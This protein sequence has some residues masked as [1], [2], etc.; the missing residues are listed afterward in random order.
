M[1][2]TAYEVN[3]DGLVGPTHHYAGLSKGNLASM[4]NAGSRSNPRAAALE[5]LDKMKFMAD[6][7]FKQAVFPPHERPHLTTLK[8]LGYTGR[9]NRIP[10]KVFKDN[11]Q[12]LYQYSSAADMFAANSATVTPSI[13]SQ[14]N[15]V[16]FTPANKLMMPHRSIEAE[17]TSRIFEVIFPSHTFFQHHPRLPFNP[18]FLDEGAANHIRFSY[19]PNDPGLHLFVCGP[20]NNET[21]KKYPS[22]QTLE[23]QKAIVRSHQL[24]LDQVIYAEHS[25]EAL[26]NG[27]FHN[28][29]ISMGTANLFIFHEQAFKDGHHLIKELSEKFNTLSGKNL[30]L[31]KVS[32][33]EISLSDAV[34]S[35]FF[36][37]Q[38]VKIPDG[39]FVLFAPHQCK[40]Y[41]RV[42]EYIEKQLHDP[43]S[44]IADIHYV[45]LDQ[46]MRNGGGPACMR[47]PVLLT[48]AE[49]EHVHPNIFL[50][51]KLYNRL[52][53]W[54]SNYY[55]ECLVPNDLTD[56]ALVDE[57]HAALNE[58]TQ[59]LN[60]GHIYD[61]QR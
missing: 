27:V 43:D 6:F 52:K 51:D 46:C 15:R 44:P 18:L 9:D 39:G 38:L 20:W 59:I 2:P 58:L 23:A 35:Y 11:P 48:S 37:S 41:P 7:G 1:N 5:E 57:T 10:E 56:P 42:K 22:R 28:D 13:D 17:T 36:N 53:D 34:K 16:H 25:M 12:I 54:I 60:L 29:V 50:T 21:A 4:E 45:N 61:F 33:E 3:F 26:N 24:S 30:L 32:K 14:N 8:A 47:L 31:L 40:V 49:L 19:N 55:R